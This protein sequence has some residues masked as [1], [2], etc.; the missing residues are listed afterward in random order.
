[1]RDREK[2]DDGDNGSK[3]EKPEPVS[4]RKGTFRDWLARFFGEA[5]SG[6]GAALDW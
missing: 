6:G 5:P 4:A 2:E 3:K 1:M